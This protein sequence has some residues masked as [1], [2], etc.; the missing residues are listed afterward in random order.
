MEK[1]LCKFEGT[2][3]D[4]CNRLIFESDQI[5]S[6]PYCVFHYGCKR[7]S[8]ED[9][10]GNPHFLQAFNE[11]LT[12]GEGNWKGFVFPAG[13]SFPKIIPFA[14]DARG[15]RLSSFEL[16]N[17]T[18]KESVDFSDSVFKESLFI[19]NAI[20]ENTANF[21][22]CQ[23]EGA[24]EVLN[25]QFEKG[26]SFYRADFSERTLLRANFHQNANFNEAIFRDVTI[27][28][29]WRNISLQLSS[30]TMS[31]SVSSGAVLSGGMN[32]TIEQQIRRGIQKTK[33]FF[34]QNIKQVKTSLINQRNK[35]QNYLRQL[36][37]KYAKTDPN[38]KLFRMFE[39]EGQFQEVV[40]LKPDKVLFSQ[41]TLSKVYFQRTNLRGVRFLGVDWWQPAFKRNGLYDELFIGKS[42][43]GAFRHLYL[44]VLEETCRNA[45]IAL[46]ENRSFN[47]ASDFYVAE[48]EAARQQKNFLAQH[49][50]SV[51]ALYRFVSQYG[52]SVG[53]A[54]RVLTLIYL[55]H[56]VSSLYIQSPVE[57]ASLLDQFMTTALR[58]IKV[59][60]LAQPDTKDVII[61]DGQS[62]LDIGLRLVGPIQIAMVVIAFRARIKRH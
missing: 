8:S 1:Q 2:T 52:T 15:C 45:R 46:E 32:L 60:L 27:F 12:S 43:D 50:F 59:L 18:F 14:V 11:I 23:F 48:M 4:K 26:G 62:W 10:L 58:S 41:V 9:I 37:R 13:I 7:R 6:E 30:A 16:D 33:S 38:A 34:Y 25:V 19:K 57:I 53:T 22:R 5:K 21:D 29:G 61:T 24:V 20:F 36:F 3:G 47:I 49:L 54:I 55:L 40:F 42:S 51:T 44:P 39:A 35:A 17:V 31:L 56:V 28:S